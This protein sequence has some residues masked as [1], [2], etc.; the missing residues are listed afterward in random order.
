MFHQMP[1]NDIQVQKY[2]YVHIAKLIQHFLS[3]QCLLHIKRKHF[4]PFPEL[5]GNRI[6]ILLCEDISKERIRYRTLARHFALW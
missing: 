4:M 1:H 5:F 3:V 2:N 6:T